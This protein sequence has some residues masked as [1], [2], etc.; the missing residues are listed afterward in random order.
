V[1]YDNVLIDIL[2]RELKKERV[3][4]LLVFLRWDIMWEKHLYLR[5]DEAFMRTGYKGLP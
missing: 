5:K 4:I 3:P 1:A 2:C